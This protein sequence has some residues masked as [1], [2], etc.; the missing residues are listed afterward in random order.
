MHALLHNALSAGGYR[1][2]GTGWCRGPK[3]ERVNSRMIDGLA[4][5]TKCSAAC[6][7]LE[8]R[9][10]NE[11]YECHGYAF[12]FGG[13]FAGRCYLYGQG[14]EKGLVW[15]WLPTEW[16]ADPRPNFVVAGTY[17]QPGVKC[18]LRGTAGNARFD[19]HILPRKT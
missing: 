15:T 6:S 16:Q 18:M 12:A 19:S 8:V 13:P 3:G 4:N 10:A 11:T 5:E 1:S 2:V 17:P 9:A 14:M 7:T